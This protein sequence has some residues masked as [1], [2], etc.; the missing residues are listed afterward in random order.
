[1]GGG[2]GVVVTDGAVDVVGARAEHLGEAGAAPEA[3]ERVGGEV[4][5]EGAGAGCGGRLGGG[6]PG[7]DDLGVGAVDE[8]DAEGAPRVGGERL[9]IGEEVVVVRGGGAIDLGGDD[10]AVGG[11]AAVEE[12]REGRLVGAVEAAPVDGAGE[13]GAGQGDVGDA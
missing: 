5:G 9:E 10:E 6:A 13:L 11:E 1:G 8:G 4:T 2:L 3:V 7:G 12:V